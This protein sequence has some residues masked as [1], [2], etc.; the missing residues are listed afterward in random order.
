MGIKIYNSELSHEIRD[1]A[2]I[3]QS[4]DGIPSELADKVIPVMEVNPKLLRVIDVVRNATATPNSNTTIYT[5]PTDRDFFLTTAQL[6]YVKDATCDIAS[7]VGPRISVTMFGE[8]TTRGILESAV[9]TL[10]ADSQIISIAFPRPIKLARGSAITGDRG[11]AFTVGNLVR[12]FS[13]TGYTTNA[14][15]A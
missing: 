12:S 5:T 1:G 15:T 10:T 3:Q 7:G 9:I 8:T 13:I 14:S 6:A 2:K 4:V 11:A